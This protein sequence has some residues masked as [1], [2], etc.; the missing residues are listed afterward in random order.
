MK[1]IKDSKN[2][3]VNELVMEFISSC[4]KI[5]DSMLVMQL[6]FLV[7]YW[8]CLFYISIVIGML[9]QYCTMMQ[10]CKTITILHLPHVL[11]ILQI[12][13]VVHML[14]VL[15]LLQILPIL[16]LLQQLQ[17]LQVLHLLHLL[18]LLQVLQ[19]L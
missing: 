16:H 15:H 10:S 11:Q 2:H 13:Q 17:L 14:Q 12:L 8:C 5:Y 1:L 4:M 9:L 19:V 18:Q 6:F 7:H 3:D